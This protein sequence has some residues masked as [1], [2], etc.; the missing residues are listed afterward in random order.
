MRHPFW[1]PLVTAFKYPVP[2]N[3]PVGVPVG[4]EPVEV[5]VPVPDF[6]R[7]FTPD[8]A[9]SDFDPSGFVFTKVPV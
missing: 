6:G 2:E 1:L 3:D 9:Q 7:Y 5:G 4:E 8:A